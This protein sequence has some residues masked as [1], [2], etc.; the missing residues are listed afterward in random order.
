MN[1]AVIMKET[2]KEQMKGKKEHPGLYNDM[3]LLFQKMI[4]SYIYEPWLQL[5]TQ[6]HKEYFGRCGSESQT[7]PLFPYLL[8]ASTT[9]GL[10]IKVMG[11]LFP[12]YTFCVYIHNS[13]RILSGKKGVYVDLWNIRLSGEQ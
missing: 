3:K 7:D 6:H 4:V 13:F 9:S 2:T 1:D 10:V 11:R 12:N 8:L 5:F